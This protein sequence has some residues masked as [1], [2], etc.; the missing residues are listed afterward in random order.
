MVDALHL[1]AS[2]MHSI[3]GQLAGQRGVEHILHRR[4]RMRQCNCKRGN[5]IVSFTLMRDDRLRRA[6]CWSL[7][8]VNVAVLAALVR[9]F[10]PRAGKRSIAADL[11]LSAADACVPHTLLS[12]ARSEERRVGKECVSTCRSRWSP[13]H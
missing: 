12:L 13:Y 9:L 4:T 6:E 10:A 2:E 1:P 3:E 5:S 7:A 11:A 8:D